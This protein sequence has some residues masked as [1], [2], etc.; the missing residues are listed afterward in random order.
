ME[1]LEKLLAS[2]IDA[3][4]ELNMQIFNIQ[5]TLSM[6]KPKPIK[7]GGGIETDTI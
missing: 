3:R 2:K 6:L 1:E 7:S 4:S 5:E